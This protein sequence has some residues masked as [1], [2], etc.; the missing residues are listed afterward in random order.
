MTSQVSEVDTV[1]N[2]PDG[3]PD[4]SHGIT[5]RYGGDFARLI[6]TNYL[7]KEAFSKVARRMI[8]ESKWIPHAR[9][10]IHLDK[11]VPVALNVEDGKDS[12]TDEER[13][14]KQPDLI[15]GY[16]RLNLAIPPHDPRFGWFLGSGRQDLGDTG[17][18]LLLTAEVRQHRVY[19]RHA[20]L[21]LHSESAV[22]MLHVD[23][24]RNILLN[25][26][27]EVGKGSRALCAVSTGLMVGELAYRVVFTGLN[28]R[29]FREQLQN[30]RRD[31]GWG[32]LDPPSTLATT[33]SQ[34]HYEYQGYIIQP[35][36]AR[37]SEGLVSP[38]INKT[39][40]EAVAVKKVQRVRGTVKLIQEEIALMKP[41]RSHV[42]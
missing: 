27:E 23:H 21:S 41:L 40:G 19:G 17:V 30:V 8:D 20:R 37:G 5:Y 6:P 10:F 35:P 38:G 15:T 18:D 31:T 22:L 7:A 32:L 9:Q 29:F 24:D 3:S 39:T 33:P 42:S 26:L 1:P 14:E 34:N 25:G 4:R 11:K 28:E 12:E 2:S 16:Y 13:M 36:F